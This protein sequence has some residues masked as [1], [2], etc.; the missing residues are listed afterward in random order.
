[1]SEKGCGSFFQLGAPP[2]IRQHN[3][4]RPYHRYS[5]RGACTL[6]RAAAMRTSEL[7]V[8]WECA[9]KKW[10]TFWLVELMMLTCRSCHFR[11]VLFCEV[12]S[13]LHNDGEGNASTFHLDDRTLLFIIVCYSFY[14]SYSLNSSKGDH[15]GDD[16]WN[17]YR[18]Y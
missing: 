7:T 18:G 6:G 15:I 1:M 2:K 10:P 4:Y 16:T 14:M 13:A 12:F 9:L 5:H 3:C 17:R 11:F 8:P